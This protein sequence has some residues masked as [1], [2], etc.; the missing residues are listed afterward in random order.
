MRKRVLSLLLTVCMLL[1]LV[2]AL[3][4]TV[5]AA[6]ATVNADVKAEDKAEENKDLGSSRF[7]TDRQV[8]VT[9][10]PMT[11]SAW[12]A[13]NG[14]TES[15][16]DDATKAAYREYF[17]TKG[18]VIWSGDWM[19]G[20]INRSTGRFEPIAYHAQ[21]AGST[22]D[23]W[24]GSSWYS[25][26]SATDAFLTQYLNGATNVLLW[27]VENVPF[28]VDLP[29]KPNS[30]R[31]SKANVAYFSFAYTV[32]AD[33]AGT[34]ELSVLDYG[35]TSIN[36]TT[37]MIIMLNDEIV[38]PN[39]GNSVSVSDS[40]TWKTDI[41]S[42]AHLN[43][44]LGELS[45]EVE[46]GDM[47]HFVITDGGAN[48]VKLDPCVTRV[49]EPAPKASTSIYDGAL[50]LPIDEKAFADYCAKEL[51]PDLDSSK[52]AYKDYVLN[53]TEK[54]VW[55]GDWT[56]GGSAVKNGALV[57][58]PIEYSIYH[59]GK[60]WSD[61]LSNSGTHYMA[62]ESF[63]ETLL[64][65]YLKSSTAKPSHWSRQYVVYG[66]YDKDRRVPMGLLNST[67]L[68][69]GYQTWMYTVPSGVSEITP[70]F[71]SDSYL[72]GQKPSAETYI[73][74]MKNGVPVWPAGATVD[75]TSTWAKKGNGYSGDAPT[76]AELNA[77]WSS[78]K[79]SV[80]EG[81][82]IAFAYVDKVSDKLCGYR[83]G[84]IDNATN[85]KNIYDP[86]I[87]SYS[88]GDVPLSYAEFCAANSPARASGSAYAQSEEFLYSYIRD[89][90][91]GQLMTYAEF[92]AQPLV[93]ED[94]SSKQA[95]RDYVLN[96]TEK[97]VWTGDWTAGGSVVKNGALVYEPITYSIYHSGKGW[98]DA[99][100]NSGT[101]YMATKST[102]ATILNE[103]LK[104]STAKPSHWGK[105]YGI[106]A[107][108][109]NNNRIPMG[110]LNST[111]TTTSYQTWMYTV[112]S[113][114]SE[115]TPY[116]SSD[117]YLWGATSST[118]TYICVMKNGVPVWPAGAT[119]D[120]TSTWAKKG[121]GYEG[122]A[123]TAAE[124]NAAWSS[125]K[126]SVTEGDQIAFAYVDKVSDKPCAYRFG[127]IDNATGTKNI[128]DP[129][130]AS[131][132]V[133]D[134]P[135]SYT[136]FCAANSPARAPG[137]AYTQN[138]DFLYSYILAETAVS[139]QGD[140]N[141]G[142]LAS[143]DDF[144]PLAN[145]IVIN[146]KSAIDG[147]GMG[148]TIYATTDAG[149]RNMLDAY[150]SG[151]TV[152]L[153]MLTDDEVFC[154]A[155]NGKYAAY[156]VGNSDD[157][158][159]AYRYTMMQNGRVHLSLNDASAFDNGNT[160]VCVTKNGEV[161]WPN[162]ASFD[163]KS[164]WATLTA[165]NMSEINSSLASATPYLQKGDNID[166][167]LATDS[168]VAGDDAFLMPCVKIGVGELP[169]GATLDERY[170]GVQVSTSGRVSL[171][172][173]YSTF[174]NADA[175]VAEIINPVSGDVK[176][177]NYPISDLTKTA[178]GYCVSVPL[179]PSQMT[180]N[181]KVYAV[182]GEDKSTAMEYS[183][184]K[185]AQEVLGSS[186][187]SDSHDAMRA[188]LNWGAMAQVRFNEATDVLAN[189]DVYA[190]GTNPINGVSSIAYSKGT[191]TNGTTITGATMNLNLKPDNIEAL[192]YVN[193]TGNGTL[194]ATVSKNGETPVSTSVMRSGNR[195]VVKIS[196]VPANLFNTPYTVTITDGTDTFVATKTIVEYLGKILESDYDDATKNT[197]KAM[198]QLYQAVTGD[199]EENCDHNV[200][201][202]YS[203]GIV[204]AG[205]T[206]SECFELLSNAVSTNVGVPATPG[207][208]IDLSKYPVVI[209]GEIIPGDQVNWIAGCSELIDYMVGGR[210]AKAPATPGIYEM[211]VV[212]D[213]KSILVSLVV[214]D[215]NGNY[216]APVT[217]LNADAE[218]DLSAYG[219]KAEADGS[220]VPE[221]WEWALNVTAYNAQENEKKVS[222][223]KNMSSFLFVTD[224][225]WEE[226]A[227]NTIKIANYLRAE[228]G[229]EN[230]YFGG[231]YM[232]G[233]KDL[234]IATETA[235]SWLAEMETFKGKWYAARGNHDQNASYRP[236]SLDHVWTDAE[237]Y[238]NILQYADNPDTSEDKLYSYI[239]DTD[240]KIRYYFL[241]D[242]SDGLTKDNVNTSTKPGVNTVLYAEQLAWLQDTAKGLD[243]GWG[244][245]VTEHR[246]YKS[247]DI[248]GVNHP[249]EFYDALI[250]ILNEID[251]TNEVIAVFAGHSHREIAT[252]TE[253][254]YYVYA[255]PHDGNTS[256]VNNH[257]PYTEYG[258]NRE[259][260]MVYVQIDREN[261]KIYITRIGM[262]V[263]LELDY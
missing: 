88:V 154:L 126:I 176:T 164:T 89:E 21:F 211:A 217:K 94:E 35:Y 72:F 149:M 70:Y 68:A 64:N 18:K 32:P 160:Y 120:N 105:D 155:P 108:Y 12:A 152:Y 17:F 116:F 216:S 159:T 36:T 38:W 111:K 14:K 179:A 1:S 162:N 115:I 27:G 248:N 232:N 147:Y 244:I 237:Y 208:T 67:G 188:L 117:S 107:R 119:V 224:M 163:D 185:Y 122:N 190:M 252:L 124:L 25:T 74:I 178:D 42:I 7:V 82:Q 97:L 9:S 123:P 22:W 143:S 137:A 80:T 121:N 136:E 259:Q 161:I 84:V 133:G 167:C 59:S 76:A 230:L 46:T 91:V 246:L 57:Y 56:A 253:G 184:A 93:P 221:Y 261:R 165:S 182:K 102:V 222:D 170:S 173:Y 130:K 4:L 30:A 189:T 256:E 20:G 144:R 219:A 69:A 148:S 233:N 194:T 118:E 236:L 262:G 157:T 49:K 109:N 168:T 153:S 247:R 75:N 50:G 43:A 201:A 199:F 238:Q 187:Y 200:A 151:E 96:Y 23:T 58:E 2:Y 13:E 66:R 239:D 204:S 225:H 240:A 48:T 79:I 223:P 156:V 44:A 192:F 139:Q 11:Y 103:Y 55:T 28:H 85:A 215:A 26:K 114:V 228:I 110:L 47:I 60:G 6:D 251:K 132:S 213:E 53:Y 51:D 180:Y 209:D 138:A 210:Y 218:I 250:P 83:F 31:F 99:I 181:V 135:L 142:Q 34:V 203:N 205:L 41:Q 146:G 260:R 150:L 52:Q 242:Y 191:V 29:T 241:A 193:Y 227:R 183:V 197:A 10:D 255:A 61:A 134:V 113:G 39:N 206:C 37:R 87:A 229:F 214:P 174:G 15:M 90:Y 169:L 235:A 63:I 81:D 33:M 220:E 86:Q 98:S 140:W 8:S 171:K 258:T 131:K 207:A 212:S 245:V 196:N 24:T 129:A 16:N 234:S 92:C 202:H 263:N 5:N 104:S 101:H 45:L 226:N 77:A 71:S 128:Y 177:I 125:L 166:F 73:C 257:L 40:S 158:V 141:I 19:T 175:F 243:E 172:F 195:W 112:P 231:D 254:G 54:L 106:Y 100:S 127:I 198:Y 62:S 145:L 65:D 186:K 249:S 3:S 95:Y 78:L